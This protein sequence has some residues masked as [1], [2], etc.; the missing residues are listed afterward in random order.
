M[1]LKALETLLFQGFWAF[2][3]YFNYVCRSVKKHVFGAELGLV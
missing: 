2:F 1:V 3:V